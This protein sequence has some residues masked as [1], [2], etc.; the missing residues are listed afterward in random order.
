MIIDQKLK[1]IQLTSILSKKLNIT[2]KESVYLM[3]ERDGKKI[4][5][6]QEQLLKDIY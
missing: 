5:L 2:S 3:V 6:N 1:I 4:H